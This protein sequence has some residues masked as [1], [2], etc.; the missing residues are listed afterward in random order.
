MEHT[1]KIYQAGIVTLN[2]CVNINPLFVHPDVNI[3]LNR[4]SLYHFFLSA[5]VRTFHCSVGNRMENTR[6]QRNR[7]AQNQKCPPLKTHSNIERTSSVPFSLYHSIRQ[8]RCVD[9]TF[10]TRGSGDVVCR[11]GLW[12]YHVSGSTWRITLFSSPFAKNSQ[13]NLAISFWQEKKVH[14]HSHKLDTNQE[15]AGPI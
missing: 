14:T 12:M 1:F 8:W 5:Y 3:F 6:H 4:V 9:G 10:A 7:W 11:P 13:I 15:Y 2:N